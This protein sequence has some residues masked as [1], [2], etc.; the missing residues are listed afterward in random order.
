MTGP[1]KS[2]AVFY[3]FL[4]VLYGCSMAPKTTARLNVSSPEAVLS[5]LAA[6][7]PSEATLQALAD[8]QIT[9]RG[10][11]YPLKLALLLK[12]PAWLRVEAIPFFGPPNFFLSVRDQTLKVFLAET[13][14]FYI[15][16]ATMDNV[17]R[18]L[19]LKMSPEE[20]IAILMG[21]YPAPS[22]QDR[23]LQGRLEGDHYRIDMGGPLKRQCLWVRMTDGFLERFEAYQ[24]QRRLY[25]V[26]FEEPLRVDGAMIPQGITIVFESEDRA[27]FSIRYAEIRI[28]KTSDPA[29]FDL[30]VPPGIK[31]THL[32]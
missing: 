15:S 7:I 19:P 29:M 2:I 27:S 3:L 21:T 14:V 4:I 30:D 32:D 13:R 1:R 18:Y 24:D 6:Q 8:I 23:F 11:R 16:P 10:G 28:L 9:T 5:S 22:G 20:M 31:P 26:R 12:K 25:Q 17:A